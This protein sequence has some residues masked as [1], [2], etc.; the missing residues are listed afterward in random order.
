MLNVPK[1][2]FIYLQRPD[3]GEWLTIGRYQVGSAVGTGSFRYTHNYVHADLPWVIDPV[4]LPFLTEDDQS[5]P[6]YSGLHDVLRDACPDAW[7]Q[8]LLQ[9]EHSLPE[10]THQARYLILA[11]NAD[12][13]GALAVGTKPTPSIAQTSYPRLQQLPLV[14]REL[15]ALSEQRP[16]LS[17]GLRRQL[18]RAAA[19]GGARPKATLRDDEG[20]YWLVK[21]RISSDITDIP[22]LE[23]FAQQWGAASGLHFAST[24]LH[25]IKE[26]HSAVSV[27]R[28]DR[29]GERRL[30]CVST[31]SLL[32]TEYPDNLGQT[33]LWS[34]PRLADALRIIGA[35][36]EDRRELFGRMVFNA[37]CGNDDDHVR[38]HAIVYKHEQRR[39]RLTPAFD[40]VPNPVETPRKLTLQLSNGR[41]DISRSAVLADADRFGFSSSEEAANYL[42]MLM[43]QVTNGFDQVAHWLE[44]DGQQMLRT[45]MTQNVA[46]L[47][48]ISKHDI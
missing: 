29:V 45:R 30:M 7:G 46:L 27:L 44:H 3:N 26:G 6:R 9:R 19:I 33:D 13:W 32:Q 10:G 15:A 2:Q 37:I 4:N 17:L 24:L 22:A 23:H 36:E 18:I 40:V 11:S 35:P 48:A 5:A 14:A 43:V 39:W 1:A 38:N 41:F 47:A 31:A 34:Y 21:P 12:R 42:D 25:T 28:Y 8:T 16:A 20:Q